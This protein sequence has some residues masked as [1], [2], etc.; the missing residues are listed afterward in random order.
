MFTS[1]LRFNYLDLEVDLELD[2]DLDLDHDHNLE[3]EADHD[4]EL[5]PDL[6]HDFDHNPDLSKPALRSVAFISPPFRPGSITATS[7]PRST[8]I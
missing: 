7:T 1:S 2:H 4:L 3:L 6:D 5:G 8:S